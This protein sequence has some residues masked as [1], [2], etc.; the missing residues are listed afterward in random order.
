MLG[1]SH[2]NYF[3]TASCLDAT[4]MVL[5]SFSTTPT[6]TFPLQSDNIFCLHFNSAVFKKYFYYKLHSTVS[7]YKLRA[8]FCTKH[9]R[10]DSPEK[11]P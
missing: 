2:Y 4:E 1:I 5:S 6:Y 8:P 11:K 3:P 9:L 10:E 7:I